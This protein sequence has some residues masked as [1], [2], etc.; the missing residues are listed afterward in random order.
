VHILSEKPVYNLK[1]VLRETGIKPDVLRAWERRYGLPMPQRS[2]GGHRLYSQRDIVIIKWLIARQH[3]GLSISSAVELFREQEASSRNP[4]EDFGSIEQP[5]P[6]QLTVFASESSLEASRQKWLKACISFNEPAAEQILNQAFSLYPVEM[7]VS[8]VIQLGMR[9]LG[10]SWFNGDISVQQEHFTSAIALRRLETLIAA[11]PPPTQQ[12]TI[13]LACPSGEWHTFS[14][15]VLNLFLRRKGFHV[16]FLGANVPNENLLETVNDIQPDLTILASQQLASAANLQRTARSL[17]EKNLQIAF[18]GRIFNSVTA[19]RDRI[20]GHFLG[21]TIEDSLLMI[22]NLVRLPM[23][24]PRTQDIPSDYQKLASEFTEKRGLIETKTMEELKRHG[25]PT[26]YIATANFHLGNELASALELGS[27]GF[28]TD[29]MTWLKGL[30]SRHNLPE[31]QLNPYLL[32]YGE[33]MRKVMNG[34]STLFTQWVN[35]IV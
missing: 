16:V 1:V 28:L 24:L 12:Q 23:P 19:L 8:Q 31:E 4:L 26:D 25:V 22:D 18:G 10:E 20:P 5:T 29:D 2:A 6:T 30:L 9:D 3:E 35:S 33:S 7:V 11:T 14:L 32:T 34:H 21:A 27:I 13:L 15:V 17:S